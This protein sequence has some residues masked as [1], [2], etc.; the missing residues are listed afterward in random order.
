MNSGGRRC[1]PSSSI[2]FRLACLHADFSVRFKNQRLKEVCVAVWGCCLC[3]AAADC[4]N[5]EDVDPLFLQWTEL[6]GSGTHYD[7]A[8][9]MRTVIFDDVAFQKRSVAGKSCLVM[10]P[11]E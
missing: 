5:K 1:R 6:I 9:S 2:V 3:A 11:F 10:A 8:S 4:S 7:A